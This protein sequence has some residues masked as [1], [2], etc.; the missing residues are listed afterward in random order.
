MLQQ[1]GILPICENL[2]YRV[3]I[4]NYNQIG[5]LAMSADQGVMSRSRYRIA[6]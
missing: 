2:G 5:C 3:L 4:I 1:I 6:H